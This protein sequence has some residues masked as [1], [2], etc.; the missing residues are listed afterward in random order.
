MA[1]STRFGIELPDE[2]ADSDQWGNIL[3]NAFSALEQRVTDR[4]NGDTI[5][6]SLA[7]SGN[8]AVTNYSETLRANGT[9]STFTIDLSLGTVHT[10]TTNANT[11]IALPASIAGKS[12]V[13]IVN[14]GGAHTVTFTG[15]GTLLFPDGVAP[16]PTS[17]AGK[18]D[19]YVFTQDGVRTFARSGG[20]NF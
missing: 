5:G 6:G 10:I 16:T 7:V 13:V 15:G 4:Q 3:N 14:Y 12:F 2:G 20:S 1:N 9:G 19:I 18:Y 8:L 11:T 17:V